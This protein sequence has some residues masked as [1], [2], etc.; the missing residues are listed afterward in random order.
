MS[1]SA[2]NLQITF[3]IIILKNFYTRRHTLYRIY[4]FTFGKKKI[5]IMKYLFAV[6]VVICSTASNVKAIQ[7]KNCGKI[8]YML[9]DFFICILWRSCSGYMLNRNFIK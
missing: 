4:F 9:H 3:H 6:L 5:N 8:S 2:L 1:K 7:L